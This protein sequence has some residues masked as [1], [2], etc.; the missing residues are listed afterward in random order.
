MIFRLNYLIEE[1]SNE[2]KFSAFRALGN[3]Y[4]HTGNEEEVEKLV[5][6]TKALEQYQEEPTPME[7]ILKIPMLTREDMRKNALKFENKE[8]KFGDTLCLHQEM[9]TNGI[10][11]LNLLFDINK[12][13]EELLP[14]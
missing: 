13:P 2:Y 4:V 8:L 3:Y 7:D 5:E 12:V 14:L 10:G 1:T 11:Y 9:F 6:K